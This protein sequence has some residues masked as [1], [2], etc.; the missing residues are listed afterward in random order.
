MK[1]EYFLY[2]IVPGNGPEFLLNWINIEIRMSKEQITIKDIAR[3]L[4]LSKS[5]VSRALNKHSDIS[6]ETQQKV[7]ELAKRLDYQPNI[8]A[9]SLK[10]QRTNTI[11]VIIPETVNIF[12]AKAVD[13]IQRT[14]NLS[15]INVIICQSNESLATEKSNLNTLLANRVDGLLVS[16]SKE[17]EN[18]DHFQQAI[19]R[20]T[21]IVFFDRICEN[22][23]TSMVYSDNYDVTLEGTEH[24]IGQGARRIAFVAGPQNLFNSR[25]RLKGYITALE[26][27]R[28]EKDESYIIYSDY[29]SKT[30]EEYTLRLLN[31][32]DRPDAVFAIN[33]MA[34]IEMMHIIKNRGLRIPDDIAIMGFNNENIC[35]YVEPSLTSID[36]PA[37]DMGTVATKL[38]LQQLKAGESRP[39]KRL[40]KS[41][42]IPRQSTHRKR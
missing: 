21:P 26:K 27:H 14:A 23:N 13:G 30:I 3:M 42:L 39:E 16:V 35:R 17:T 10:H 11:G 29:A 19:D 37:Y 32:A 22:L 12:F 38:L 18:S 33:D 31:M 5:T 2:G 8:V 25:N 9:Q 15:G 36:H 1:Y 20:G 7:I 4:G 40:I 41:Q 24:L 6:Q 34:A 28:I